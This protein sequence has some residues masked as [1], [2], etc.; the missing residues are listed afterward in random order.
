M[1][2][3]PN[4]ETQNGKR[5]TGKGKRNAEN[6]NW[7][8]EKKYTCC[9]LQI[10]TFNEEHPEDFFVGLR[11]MELSVLKNVKK[12]ILKSQLVKKVI[13]PTNQRR[14]PKVIF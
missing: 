5:K 9:N 2:K 12:R 4:T 10:A 8:T 1:K 3:L 11:R 7:E 14:I 13:G 6:L